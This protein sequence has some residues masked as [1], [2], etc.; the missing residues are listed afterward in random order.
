MML[1]TKYEK[2]IVCNM[3]IDVVYS[4]SFIQAASPV[5]NATSIYAGLFVCKK[6]EY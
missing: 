6:K 1:T 3:S 4:N 2:R 5:I